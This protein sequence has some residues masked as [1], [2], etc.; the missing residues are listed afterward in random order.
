MSRTSLLEER[1]SDRAVN[2][3]GSGGRWLE[4]KSHPTAFYLCDLEKI[5]ASQCLRFILSEV[6]ILKVSDS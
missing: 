5:L 4:F 1:L 6:G 2:R 3:A